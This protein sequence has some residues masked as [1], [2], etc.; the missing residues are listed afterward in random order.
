MIAV[1]VL[2]V[3]IVATSRIFGTASQ[4]TG[5]GQAAA[6][7]LQEAGAIERR[8][9][10]DVEQLSPEGFLAIRCVAVRNS[11]NLQ[12][13]GPLL[14]PELPPGEWIRAD[15]ILFFTN[16][17]Q[18]VQGFRAAAGIQRKGQGTAARVYYGH[19]WQVPQ[20]PPA[21]FESDEVTYGIDPVLDATDPLVPWYRGGFRDFEKI[22]FRRSASTP[23]YDYSSG[24]G[25]GAFSMNQP[26]A[27]G[28]VLARQA[29]VLADDG[30]DP[31][32][33]G[34]NVFLAAP[35]GEGGVRTTPWIGDAVIVN[36]RVDAS[37]ARLGNLARSG[38][39]EIRFRVTDDPTEHFDALAD[40]FPEQRD[41]IG[42][43]L[44]YPRAE[45]HA[46]SMSRVDQALT[47][48]TLASA[49]S[50][51]TVDWT[52]ADGAGSGGVQVNSIAA[53]PW[54]GLDPVP[55]G[56][57][58]APGPRD[59]RTFGNYVIDEMG[60]A[61]AALPVRAESIERFAPDLSDA[62]QEISSADVVVY[63]AFFG[64]NQTRPRDLNGAA[65]DADAPTAYTPLPTAIRLTMTLHDPAG[66][67]AA[68]RV[69]QFVID[70]PRRG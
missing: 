34:A 14:D 51:F 70:L 57:F 23:P 17:V 36:G 19:G 33:G 45:R 48:H 35:G 28:W 32:A 63:E 58:G 38:L 3:V 4:V 52:Y 18:S 41:V 12:A 10:T 5:M 49:C 29:V 56:A 59:V 55:N 53:Q 61:N 24:G 46:P 42:A 7:V 64:C 6:A 50:S 8:L 13:G 43:L 21:E 30:G 15:Q 39:A 25:A 26:P 2:L 66:K 67:L 20:A 47:D 31:A 22:R 60:G 65:W 40:W 9:R 54:F 62:G 1:L 44:F 69:V 27:P 11:V 16:G 68:G 37:A